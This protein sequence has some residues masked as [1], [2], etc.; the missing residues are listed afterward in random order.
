MGVVGLDTQRPASQGIEEIR[1]SF[2]DVRD[3]DGLRIVG[4]DK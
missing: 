4:A 3:G 1:V 2:R